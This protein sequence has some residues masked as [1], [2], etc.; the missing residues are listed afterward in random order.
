MDTNNPEPTDTETKLLLK[1]EVYQIVGASLEVL[2]GVGHGLHE[3]IY[4][5]SLVVEFGLRGIKADQQL[6]FPVNY[7]GTRVGEFIPDLIAFGSVV[8]DAKGIDRIG[9]HE[10][11]QMLNYLRITKLRV[12]V[13]VNFKH[14]R[15]EWERIVL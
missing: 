2:K 3:K 8:V 12:G 14:P 9:D 5:N 6:I 15:L 11:G 10:R 13:L 7:K 1:D 4:E